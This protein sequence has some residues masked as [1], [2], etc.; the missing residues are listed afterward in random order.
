MMMEQNA[1]RLGR[2]A[3]RTRRN[4]KMMMEQNA[5]RLGRQARNPTRNQKKQDGTK[6]VSWKN[7]EPHSAPELF[8]EIGRQAPEPQPEPGNDD[9]TGWQKSTETSPGTLPGI[10]NE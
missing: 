10:P 6:M 5:K 1:K 7:W 3:P 8:G 9:G 2:Q 4:Q